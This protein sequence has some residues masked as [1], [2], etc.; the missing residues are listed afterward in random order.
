MK[1]FLALL[2]ILTAI[3]AQAGTLAKERWGCGPVYDLFALLWD[4]PWPPGQLYLEYLPDGDVF[5]KN[6]GGAVPPCSLVSS[7]YYDTSYRM[8]VCQG[9]TCSTASQVVLIPY[10]TCS[11]PVM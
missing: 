1:R 6:Y 4:G 9:A 10:Q 2:V 8:R 11:G 7:P 3:P 5:W